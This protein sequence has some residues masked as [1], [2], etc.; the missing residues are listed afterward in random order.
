MAIFI[1]FL[2]SQFFFSAFHPERIKKICNI[3]ACCWHGAQR[4]V[5]RSNWKWIFVNFTSWWVTKADNFVRFAHLGINSLFMTDIP[6]YSTLLH[7]PRHEKRLIFNDN[8]HVHTL[9][10]IYTYVYGQCLNIC[11]YIEIDAYHK[12]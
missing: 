1:F 5:C 12:C 6:F 7:S 8:D 3:L 4:N 10:I 2:F 9:C 11:I